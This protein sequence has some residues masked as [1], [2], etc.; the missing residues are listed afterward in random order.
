MTAHL[1]A[2]RSLPPHLHT[3]KS[4]REHRRSCVQP[5]SHD[6]LFTGIRFTPYKIF[7]LTLTIVGTIMHHKRKFMV[8]S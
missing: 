6:F 2:L 3:L 8:M 5:D 7:Y 1:S 4:E